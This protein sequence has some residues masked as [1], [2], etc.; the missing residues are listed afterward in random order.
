MA[1]IGL[2]IVTVKKFMQTIWTLTMPHGNKTKKIDWDNDI[3]EKLFLQFN[4][5]ASY[6][7][8]LNKVSVPHYIFS[9]HLTVGVK[10]H[11]FSD[12]S[13][14]AYGAVI[15]LHSVDSTGCVRVPLVTSSLVLHS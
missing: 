4:Y 1:L 6:F 10:L 7:S 12:A 15:Y 8:D 9:A 2:V 13:A 3:P 11:R 14:F 5:F